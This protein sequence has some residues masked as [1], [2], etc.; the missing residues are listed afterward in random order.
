MFL[1][2]TPYRV[3]MALWL[4]SGLVAAQ[5]S[6]PALLSPLPNEHVLPVPGAPCACSVFAANSDLTA[7]QVLLSST[8]KEARAN[9]KGKVLAFPNAGRTKVGTKWINK[10]AK[11]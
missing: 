8:S 10:Y 4:S 7:G 1:K 3:A 9:F 11:D 2:A 6:A 5:T